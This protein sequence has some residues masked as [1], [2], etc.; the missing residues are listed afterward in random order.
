MYHNWFEG[1][2]WE[3]LAKK[4]RIVRGRT[5]LQ[6]KKH[7]HPT[8]EKARK[9]LKEACRNLTICQECESTDTIQIHHRD[10]NPFNNSLENLDILCRLCHSR[11]H[12]LD[13]G[14]VGEFEG[15]PYTD[16][17]GTR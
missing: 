3:E 16:E 4:W 14:V 12:H 7:F 17:E 2:S 6:R 1:Y 5:E 10:R 9:L 11:K 8:T 13:F 15:I